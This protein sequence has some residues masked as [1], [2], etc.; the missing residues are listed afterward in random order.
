MSLCK[1]PLFPLFN[2]LT[3]IPFSFLF[4]SKQLH[5]LLSSLDYF[6]FLLLSL[7]ILKDIFY[8]NCINSKVFKF[9]V[10]VYSIFTVSSPV[11]VFPAHLG[12]VPAVLLNNVSSEIGVP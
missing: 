3:T 4:I 8:L 12:G 1:N 11:C 9:A 5:F 6:L 2:F 10:L 7:F